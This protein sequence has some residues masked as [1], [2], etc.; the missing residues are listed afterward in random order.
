MD[1]WPS[2]GPFEA[3]RLLVGPALSRMDGHLHMRL[4]PPL[5]ALPLERAV[6]G[7]VQRL[8]SPRTLRTLPVPRG[9]VAEL[10]AAA[11]RR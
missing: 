10:R 6:Q 5:E 3:P 8:H 1:T 9:Q 4:H 2:P 11:G 7:Y